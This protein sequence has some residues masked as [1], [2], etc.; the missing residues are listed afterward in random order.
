MQRSGIDPDAGKP[1]TPKQ[2]WQTASLDGPIYGSPLVYGSRVY[3]ATENDT[4]YA[5]DFATGALVWKQHVATAVPNTQLKCGDI[6]PTVGITG[7]PVIDPATGRIFVVADTWDGSNPSSIR[8]E[9]FGLSVN[10]GVVAS[11]LPVAV[12]PPGSHPDYQLQRPGLALDAGRIVIG[13]GGNDGDCGEFDGLYH[14][15]VVS[16]PESGGQLNSFEVAQGSGG[17]AVWGAGSG[18]PVDSAGNVWAETGNSPGLH[19]TTRSPSSGSTWGWARRSTI[20][21]RPT[22]NRSTAAMSTSD[23][24]SRVLLPGGLVFAIGKEGVGYL[25]S[26]SALGGTGAD[27]VFQAS[28]C[29][30]SFGGGI[31]VS[32][33]IYVTCTDGIHAL[34]LDTQARTFASLGSWNSPAARSVRRSTRVAWSGRRAGRT[35]ASMAS[36]RRPGAS[37]SPPASAAST[38]SRRPRPV[39]GCC[40][41]RTTTR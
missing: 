37:R 12:D 4:V 32:G 28:V 17:G 19:S 34:S 7:T 29:G 33:V 36:I 2:V 40:S 26:A 16:V 6:E 9:L 41:S 8:H 3:V 14:G 25:L 22:G 5:L 10:T 21:R 15:W 13:Y 18:L 24:V 1:L 11:G 31:V 23:R 30:G 38:I 39:A 35:A 27:P 20:G